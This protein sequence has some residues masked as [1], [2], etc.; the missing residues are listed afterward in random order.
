M[1]VNLQFLNFHACKNLN[2]F[3]YNECKFAIFKMKMHVNL[4][5][6]NEMHVNLNNFLCKACK[7]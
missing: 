4:K 1:H 3:K 2:S 6:F 7:V 5:S